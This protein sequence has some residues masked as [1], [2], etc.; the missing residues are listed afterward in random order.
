VASCV[1]DSAGLFP[2]IEDVTADFVYVRLHGKDELCVSGY[3]DAALDAWAMRIDAWSRAT[4]TQGASLAAPQLSPRARKQRDVYVYFDNDA[5]IRA[6]FDALT[7]RSKL[8][9]GEARD[10]WPVIATRPRAR[11][12]S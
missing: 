3:D 5:K 8:R 6:P 11:R 4:Q 2:V 9:G 10:D 12:A 1:A 7:L